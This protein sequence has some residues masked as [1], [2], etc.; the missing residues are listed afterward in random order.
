M[1]DSS[2]PL[3][4]V[5]GI[6]SDTTVNS[7]KLSHVG[8]SIYSN[9]VPRVNGSCSVPSAKGSGFCFVLSVVHNGIC[10]NVMIN[11]S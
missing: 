1:D 3:H 8:S 6:R 11:G 5:N 2:T 4:E 10:S 7:L 9:T